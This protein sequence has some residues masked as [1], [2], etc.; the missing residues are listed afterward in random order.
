MR[1]NLCVG[2]LLTNAL[3]RTFVVTARH[4]GAGGVATSYMLRAED[5]D[6]RRAELPKYL[7]T[8]R[9]TCKHD[10]TNHGWGR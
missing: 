1:T 3:G 10:R 6:R 7:H 4:L 9:I 2:D 8:Y 5:N